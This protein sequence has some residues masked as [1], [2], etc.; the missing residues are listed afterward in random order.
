MQSDHEILKIKRGSSFKEVRQAY[1]KQVMEW[2]PDRFP[3]DDENLQKQATQNFHKITDAYKRLEIWHGK[4]EQGKYDEHQPDYSSPSDDRAASQEGW[5]D[6]IASDLPQFITRTWKNGDKYE[7]MAIS[8]RMHGQGIF[9]YANGSVYSGQFRYGNMNGL[10]K[11]QFSNGDVYSGGFLENQFHGQGKMNFSN[12]DR[13]MGYFNKD[14]YHGEGV[15]V[16]SQGNVH[17]GQWDHGSLMSE[18]E[19]PFDRY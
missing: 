7:G 18:P 10:G 9:T 17:A 5:E 16:T 8:E 2:H 19:P 11:F 4:K 3:A 14:Q 12:G 6:D 13:Y 1:K 15:F